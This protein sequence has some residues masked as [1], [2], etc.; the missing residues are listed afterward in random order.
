MTEEA[1]KERKGYHNSIVQHLRKC[2]TL[3]ESQIV[4]NT[5]VDAMTTM[6][7]SLKFEVNIVLLRDT[8][9]D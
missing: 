7:K 5:I 6:K 3:S 1:V 4:L 2:S 8:V 9:N